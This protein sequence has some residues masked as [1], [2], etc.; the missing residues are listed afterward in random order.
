M[1]RTEGGSVGGNLRERV[2]AVI[3]VGATLR[4]DDRRSIDK[5]IGRVGILYV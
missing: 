5:G 1:Q 3:K 2:R 4:V